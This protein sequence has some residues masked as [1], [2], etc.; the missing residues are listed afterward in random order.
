MTRHMLAHWTARRSRF[1]CV[2]VLLQLG[3]SVYESG[4]ELSQS[5][6]LPLNQELHLRFVIVFV[7]NLTHRSRMSRVARLSVARASS[8]STIRR[9][10][11]SIASSRS[12]L[13]KGRFSCNKRTGKR[14]LG[15]RAHH[16]KS[17]QLV[18]LIDRDQVILGIV[19][20]ELVLPEVYLVCFNRDAVRRARMR[21][22]YSI[23]PS[24]SDCPYPGWRVGS[25]ARTV[26]D[27][28]RMSL[29]RLR[30]GMRHAGFT[31]SSSPSNLNGFVMNS[32]AR[33]SIEA[34][35]CRRRSYERARIFGPNNN[36][37]PYSSW[38][39][40][41]SGVSTDSLVRILLRF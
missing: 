39:R 11:C 34:G 5:S 16:V 31:V 18:P 9:P 4:L 29:V 15:Y 33:S 7:V 14:L 8:K 25:T 21:E 28:S 13:D 35:Y 10:R 37:L 23:I 22:D 17:D 36:S 1:F 38:R 19:E 27:R 32:R 26:V 40:F 20:P 12:W 3:V 24:L 2:G 6:F 41:S 30:T